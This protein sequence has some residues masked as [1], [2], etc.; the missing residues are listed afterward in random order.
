[1]HCLKKF[2]RPSQSH[3]MHLL[4][5]L[6][7]FYRPKWQ[8]SI[9]LLVIMSSLPFHMPEAWLTEVPLSVGTSRYESLRGAPPFPS[10]SLRIYTSIWPNPQEDAINGFV[11][12][13]GPW[14]N[15]HPRH[16]I[17]GPFLR[18]LRRSERVS[19]NY[20]SRNKIHVWFC[21]TCQP[22]GECNS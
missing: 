10:I 5:L 7:L 4:V 18:A 21:W 11:L 6:G 1:M 22:S 16:T 12:Q 3:K 13:F 2:S 9:L 15:D 17:T 20:I 8:N 14:T 19:I